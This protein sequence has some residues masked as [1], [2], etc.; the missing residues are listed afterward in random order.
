MTLNHWV[1]YLPVGDDSIPIC[2]CSSSW[3][4]HFVYWVHPNFRWL[5]LRVGWLDLDKIIQNPHQNHLFWLTNPQ[6][7][8]MKWACSLHKCSILADFPND[9]HEIRRWQ[10][11]SPR[12][13]TWWVPHARRAA[14][15][16]LAL[17]VREGR[18]WAF[19]GAFRV[20]WWEFN[21]GLMEV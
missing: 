14:S 20:I 17:Q 3:R 19:N 16:W 15:R 4:W 7:F 10:V 13:T 12:A 11:G 8:M 1:E 9:N 2:S 18:R 21:G 5:D 6:M